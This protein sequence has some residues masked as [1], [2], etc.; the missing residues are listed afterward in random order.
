MSEDNQRGGGPA[1]LKT[2]SLK[3]SPEQEQEKVNLSAIEH[4]YIQSALQGLMVAG[5]AAILQ[6]QI[7]AGEVIGLSI[8]IGRATYKSVQDG[9]IPQA[10]V[11]Q[12]PGN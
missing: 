12:R 1:L 7:N 9:A 5:G 2:T 4:C 3:N 10:S 8:A 6:N 11:I